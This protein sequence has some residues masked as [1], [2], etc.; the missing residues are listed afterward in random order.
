MY[1]VA[2]SR[3]ILKKESITQLAALYRAQNREL[4]RLKAHEWKQNNPAKRK[5]NRM[6]YKGNVK[7]ATPSWSDFALMDIVYKEAKA[8]TQSTG[9][10]HD[11]DHIVPLKGRTVCGLHCEANLQVLT[12][13]DNLSKLNIIWPD[14]W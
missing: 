14:M 9:I 4:L 7:Q 1:E 10:Q 8:L 3:Y 5:Q 6:R 12:H 2:N 11:V 13:S